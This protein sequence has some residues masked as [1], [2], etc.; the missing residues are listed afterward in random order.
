MQDMQSGFPSQRYLSRFKDLIL[1]SVSCDWLLKI[2]LTLAWLSQT[3]RLEF[4]PPSLSL[5]PSCTYSLCVYHCARLCV[6][7]Q[8]SHVNKTG[9]APTLMELAVL[10]WNLW[11]SLYSIFP[12]SWDH[13]LSSQEELFPFPPQ[14]NPVLGRHSLVQA[15]VLDSSLRDHSFLEIRTSK[16]KSVLLGGSEVRCEAQ[17]ML[18]AR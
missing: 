18:V 5:P 13:P 15:L 7:Y 10:Q 16:R 6:G 14:C 8:G 4:L 3:Q 11:F 1:I 12:F 2:L 17:G 9:I